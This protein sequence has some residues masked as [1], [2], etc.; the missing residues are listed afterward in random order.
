[1]SSC[2]GRCEQCA[3]KKDLWCCLRCGLVHCGRGSQAH[4]LKHFE[5]TG[6]SVVTDLERGSHY[7][8]S[9]DDYVT[10]DDENENLHRLTQLIAQRQAETDDDS[11]KSQTSHNEP[12]SRT[13]ESHSSTRRRED[14]R[15]GA[16]GIQN[17]GNTC[18]M[19]SVLQS[20]R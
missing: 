16:V 9:C 6:H 20:L 7:C 1:M 5:D 18:F 13:R 4:G 10:N 3:E 12:A 11:S 14:V 19:N 2:G 8:Y 17:L 15:E